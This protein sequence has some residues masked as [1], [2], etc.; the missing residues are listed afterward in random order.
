MS[1]LTDAMIVASPPVA[2]AASPWY[3]AAKR[4]A[5][6]ILPILPI[7]ATVFLD[8][9]TRGQ[10]TIDP[11]WAGLVTTILVAIQVVGKQQKEAQR[12][13]AEARLEQ[14]GLPVGQ[15]LHPDVLRDA[16]YTDATLP[17]K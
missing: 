9:I 12:Q 4:C 11:R 3:L 1:Q 17:P 14:R 8:A 7:L 10:I 13:E 6:L 15:P 5:Q 2:P 16:L